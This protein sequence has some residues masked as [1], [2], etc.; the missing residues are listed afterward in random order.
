MVAA[1]E[2]AVPAFRRTASGPQHVG[3]VDGLSDGWSACSAT[4]AWWRS[5]SGAGLASNLAS[6]VFH[7]GHPV[8]GAGFEDDLRGSMGR[9]WLTCGC[10]GARSIAG[11]SAGCSARCWSFRHDDCLR[12]GGCRASIMQRTWAGWQRACCGPGTGA[13]ARW[14]SSLY[15]AAIVLLAGAVAGLRR[16]AQAGIPLAGRAGGP[17]RIGDFLREGCG[18]HRELE[19]PAGSQGGAT[20]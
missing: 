8:S 16:A 2:R 9:C 19:P 17:A 20:A 15:F 13:A 6:I 14:R 3:A 7:A 11:S 4:R 18:D 12:A 10:T 1:G 5:T